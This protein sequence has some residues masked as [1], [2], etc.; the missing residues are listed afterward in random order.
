ML[1][2]FV[3][4][5][6]AGKTT[7]LKAVEQSLG[8]SVRV[9]NA[10][11]L[12]CGLAGC[13]GLTHPTLQNAV[14]EIVGLPFFLLSLYPRRAFVTQSARLALRGVPLGTHW[15]TTP[16]SIE[17]KLGVYALSR[18]FR[19]R[20]VLVDE[21]PILMAHQFVCGAGA[22]TRRELESFVDTLP[23]PDA[24]VC[25]TAPVPLLVARTRHRD[26][27]PRGLRRADA[28]A[29]ARHVDAASALFSQLVPLLQE[30]RPVLVID[31]ADPSSDACAP[32]DRIVQFVRRHAGADAPRRLA[33]AEQ[34]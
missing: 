8:S 19:D 13:R 32:I 20:I 1:V 18:M 4:C 21:G 12:V 7:L 30:R 23:L 5:T 25:V 28:A 31:N 22:P 9:A 16:R 17:R 24:V 33:R 11:D 15:V 3:G 27:A 10:A 14:Q 2:E 34:P 29:I 6:G 26:D